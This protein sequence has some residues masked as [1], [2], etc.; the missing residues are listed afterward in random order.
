M[1]PAKFGRF[2]CPDSMQNGAHRH[3]QQRFVDNV[4]ERMSG[5][6]VDRQWRSDPDSNHHETELVVQTVREHSTQIVFDHGEHD[7]EQ[8]CL[9]YT[10]PSP[11]D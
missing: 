1:K 9:L 4:T 3:E 11:R 2:G 10:S 6:A 7:R 8:R 5:R